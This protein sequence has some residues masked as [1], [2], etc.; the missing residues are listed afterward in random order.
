[1]ESKTL[2]K[3]VYNAAAK[4]V[5]LPAK[6]AKALQLADG[7]EL[8]VSVQGRGLFV[9]PKKAIPKDEAWFWTPEHQ[10]REREADE[11]IRLGRVS[12]PFTPEESR[13]F[14][15]GLHRRVSAKR[16]AVSR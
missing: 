3:G 16:K 6:I 1:M 10:A 15:E 8:E 13:A 4:S 14:L 7:D 12:G 9:V 5:S 2:P 11:D